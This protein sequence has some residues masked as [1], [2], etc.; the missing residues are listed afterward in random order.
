[1][2]IALRHSTILMGTLGGDD[3]LKAVARS[4]S[5]SIGRNA[6]S[7]YRYGGDEFAVIL[8]GVQAEQAVAVAARINENLR[9][10]TFQ[11]VTLSFGV[12][13]FS[14]EM[15]SRTLFKHADKAMYMAKKA[16]Y[17]KS[18]A[19]IN[20]IYVYGSDIADYRILRGLEDD[21][22]NRRLTEDSD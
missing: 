4:L 18:D 19:S 15:D 17:A 22:R 9:N 5:H 1:M 13:E 16:A 21:T 12:A 11:H 10:T 8:P 3:I 7:G 2:W 14:P 6:D 20:K